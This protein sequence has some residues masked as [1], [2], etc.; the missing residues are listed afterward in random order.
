M[1]KR[2][3]D[4]TKTQN[5][6]N[7]DIGILI[8][9]IIATSENAQSPEHQGNLFNLIKEEENEIKLTSNLLIILSNFNQCLNTFSS[10]HN[11]YLAIYINNILLKFK[12][13]P[14]LSQISNLENY[15]IEGINF[16]LSFSFISNNEN[17]NNNF[18]KMKKIF[19]EIIASLFDL[20]IVMK[21]PKK[22]LELLYN[23]IILIYLNVNNNNSNDILSYQSMTKFIYIYES[24]NRIYLI[25][26]KKEQEIKIIFDKYL[27]LLK[28][29]KIF[30][31]NNLINININEEVDE[32]KAKLINQCIL[33]FSKTTMLSLEN[34]IKSHIYSISPHLKSDEEN[35][36]N[37]FIFA[38]DNSFLEFISS[39][40]YY[41]N[42]TNINFIPFGLEYAYN[43]QKKFDFLIS[44]GKGILI[45]TLFVIV[46]K[47]T[48]F[49]LFY[50]YEKF[51]SFIL[52][53]FCRIIEYLINFYKS[54]NYPR[55]KANNSPEEI[56]QLSVIV[57]I[58]NFID[59]MINNQKYQKLIESNKY[60]MN[61]FYQ[62]EKHE[63]IFKYIIVPNLLQTDLE[64]SFFELDKDEYTK[65][66]FDMCQYCEVK[67]PKQKS[68]KLLMTICYT[69][70]EFLKYIV[71]IYILILK[72]I[73][74]NSNNNT[75][76]NIII[77]DKFS[78]LY[79]FLTQNINEFNLIEQSLQI[80]TSLSYLIVDNQ[81]IS[82]YFC[83][84]IDIINYI[85]IKITDPFLKSKLCVFYS[86]NL[87]IL[88]HNND[89]IISKSFDD[90]LN[91]MFQC[92]LNKDSKE[93]L[94]KTAFNCINEVIFNNYLKKFCIT[95]VSIYLIEAINYFNKK[96]NLVGYEE[97]FNEFLKGI[98]KEYMYDLGD[99]IIDLFDLFWNK[100]IESLNIILKNKNDT[101]DKKI[102]KDK[103]KEVNEEKKLIS[104]INIIKNFINMVNN[105]NANIKNNVHEKVLSLF[106]ILSSIIDINFEEEI[107]QIISKVILN[108]K[109]LPDSYFVHFKNFFNSLNKII[110]NNDSKYNDNEYRYN[111][112]IYHLDFIFVCLQSFRS[113]IISKENIK[114]M[115][116]NNLNSRLLKMR[117][118]VPIK[119]IFYEHYVY[120]DMGLCLNLF[121]FKNFT[122]SEIINLAKIFYR[123]ME[124]IP[125][126]DY[127]LNVKL[128]INIF[129]ILIQ[130]DNFDIYDE[131]FRNNKVI[132][133]YDFLCKVISFLPLKNLYLVQ[134]EIISI[135]CTAIIRYLIV[136]QKNCEKILINEDEN[137]K[138]IDSQ[139]IF[140]GILSL[141]LNQLNIIKNI[142][143]I[144]MN[145]KEKKEEK[146]LR[147]NLEKEI[148]IDSYDI[149][150]NKGNNNF[151]KN[152][153]MVYKERIPHNYSIFKKYDYSNEDVDYKAN[154]DDFLINNENSDNNSDS[155]ENS[156]NYDDENIDPKNKEIEDDISDDID[157]FYDENNDIDDDRDE[158]FLRVKEEK[159]NMFMHYYRKYANE[160]LIL[161]LKKINEF[162]LF[163]NVMKEI[164]MYDLN[165]YNQ[166]LNQI[167]TSQGK[168]KLK[169]IEDFKGLQKIEFK[170]KN[171]FSYR[172]ILKIQKK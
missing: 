35:S 56:I 39:C 160:E 12:V 40:F 165:F 153:K 41:D 23:K 110:S 109:L 106:P 90:S 98:M 115:I 38:N 96:E 49:D 112:Q 170:E 164:E 107:F 131:I 86:Y 145:K 62:K 87:E 72:N 152:R 102:L 105:K 80:L 32:L 68:I 29:F 134:Q 60:K 124:K 117:R 166:L 74:L 157:D 46:K 99:S 67:L 100:F 121:F 81:E 92:L 30:C 159:K 25:Y 54:G 130:S 172:K 128:I 82:E 125:N 132:N 71:Q 119:L 122:N 148:I 118:Y 57:K 85:L 45:E 53:S 20:I 11:L 52:N 15:V 77:D 147:K 2:D 142:S 93:S 1:D 126:T 36:D 61:S 103:T 44:K 123:R 129:L 7:N 141:N 91:F 65:N 156:D 97:E 21:E 127:D 48:K 75:K 143:M 37:K 138:E 27:E 161:Y 34:F 163:E 31:A 116:I 149:N 6:N 139:K 64:K 140:Y 4:S 33:S 79:L 5:I 78:S 70:N 158:D 3:N 111:I 89:E 88:F 144:S 14:K 137:I 120:C 16:Y 8:N 17:D 66:L 168:E 42:N 154:E 63:E 135:F 167:K 50:S 94:K 95:S 114:E 84:E 113:N 150:E 146:K 58:I 28:F 51:N 18:S 19:D 43:N 9:L 162:Q 76:S 108:I 13:K 73:S 151:K 104:N 22:F 169:L 69:S 59:E 10:L 171:A 24:F 136:K 83:D 55:E 101:Q 47:L 155:D 26:I 133:L